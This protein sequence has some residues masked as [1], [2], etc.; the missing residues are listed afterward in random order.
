MNNKID[1]D[2]LQAMLSDSRYGRTVHY[3]AET[4]STQNIAEQ[5]LAEGAEDGL[6]VL[7]ET[8]T[9]GRGRYGRDWF[10]PPGAGIYMSLV[11]NPRVPYRYLPQLTIVTAAALSRVLRRMTDLDVRLKWPNDLYVNNRKISGILLESSQQAG[12]SRV[13]MGCGISVNIPQ[14]AYPESLQ[15]KATSLL[16]ASGK[17]WERE[18][19]IA[20]FLLELEQLLALY[21]SSGFSVFRSI[22]E[23]YAWQPQEPIE[24]TTPQGP[25]RGMPRTIDEEGALVV[26]LEDGKLMTIYAGEIT[27]VST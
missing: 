9:A 14:E 15:N 6:L 26:E 19:I 21:E 25:V 22:W 20:N 11:L 4:S 24:L 18:S 5:M 10:S 8:Q 3:V 23:A 17:Q 2:K 12:Q 7:A 13:I 27:D 16:A 1:V